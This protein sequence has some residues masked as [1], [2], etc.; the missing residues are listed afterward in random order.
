MGAEEKMTTTDELEVTPGHTDVV[1]STISSLTP[2]VVSPMSTTSAIR[3]D[4][5]S[6]RS[7]GASSGRANAGFDL[8]SV[9]LALVE[10][11]PVNIMFCD[12]DLI[13]RYVNPA[14]MEALHAL[15][16]LLPVS[17]DEVVGS[18]ID[19]FHA[20]PRSQRDL[21]SEPA[22]LPCRSTIQLGDETLD[23]LITAITDTEGAHLGAMATWESVTDPLRTFDPQRQSSEAMRALLA[24]ISEHA[25]SLAS[26]SEELTSTAT[27]LSA[28]AEQTSSQAG[29][30]ATASEQIAASLQT[31]AS[32]TE[33]MTASITEI[34]R[35]AADA[36]AVGIEAVREAEH[37]NDTV[38]KLGESS[39]DIGK[40]TKVITSIAQ[41]TN[42]LAL[43]AT[44]EAARAGEA[45]KGFAVVANEV[46]E[47]AKETAR[48]TE[49]ISAKI[50]AIQDDTR[51]SVEAIARISQTIGRIN[52]IQTTIASAVEQ[53]TATTSEIARS[54]FEVSQ[55]TNQ[56]TENITAAAEMARS[57]AAGASD[58]Q[59]AAVELSQLASEL[60]Q[61]V[62]DYND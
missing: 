29:V 40:V 3:T 48:A 1:L 39:A 9:S 56:I 6:A 2:E 27:Q 32:G 44:I 28:G 51:K 47:L 15:Q 21:L 30:V 14:S 53:Q 10:G 25:T 18:S 13:I 54:V 33:E 34:A 31:V 41:Q 62:A 17:V 58:A 52:D 46:K 22:N 61:F 19:I 49:E 36:M 11:A 7:N 4:P 45:G 59:S 5:A 23:L 55:G 8:D 12:R 35:N 16:S 20:D 42:L 38:A 50:E 37:T 43:N 57:S 26:A 60:Q 24:Q